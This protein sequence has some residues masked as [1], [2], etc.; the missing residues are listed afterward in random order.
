MLVK[1]KL[2]D[3]SSTDSSLN[4]L[5]LGYKTSHYLI[6]GVCSLADTVS[7]F[8]GASEQAVETIWLLFV[9]LELLQHMIP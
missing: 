6:G 3:V 7:V 2:L 4:I 9:S 8:T 1:V 5:S